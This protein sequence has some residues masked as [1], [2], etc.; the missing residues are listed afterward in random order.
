M[1]VIEKGLFPSKTSPRLGTGTS[2]EYHFGTEA[3]EKLDVGDS[4][5]IPVNINV[6]NLRVRLTRLKEREGVGGRTFSIFKERHLN[7]YRIFRT[8]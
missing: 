2:N 5:L 6:D 3:Y 7:Q 8:A 1:L 4:S